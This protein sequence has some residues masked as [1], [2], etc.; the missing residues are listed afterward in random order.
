M[1]TRE[2]A[3]TAAAAAV[4]AVFL[5]PLVWMVAASLRE[6]GLPA[7]HTVEWIPDPLTP[8]NYPR[9]FEMLP[10]GRYILNSLTVVAVSVPLTLLTASWAG[11][12]MALVGPRARQALFVTSVLVM[13]VPI[14]AVWLVRYVL[15][16]RLDLLD[17]MWALA[18]PSLAG[19]SPFFVLLFYWSFRRIP[20]EMFDSAL[21]EG[22]GPLRLWS[23]VAMPLAGPTTLAVGV[24]A[25]VLYWSDFI[26]PLL[27]LKTESRYTLAV[28]LQQ[29]QQL[30]RTNWPLL[31]AAA[32]L[33]TAPVIGL[34]MLVQRL[35]LLGEF[36]T[37][38]EG[39][40]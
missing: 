24:L 36:S 39:R 18:A 1:T 27:Y 19:S 21:L 12:A 38:V 6:P 31:M 13:M 4:S 16:A 28:G 23:S 20:R 22:A 26:S 7:P 25:A 8:S 29:L 30:D 34:F 11:L 15:F 40:G 5:L 32:T 2:G 14:T 35:A 33:M 9:L 3:H 10:F 37:G 17:T